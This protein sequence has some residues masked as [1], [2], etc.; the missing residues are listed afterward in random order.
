MTMNNKSLKQLVLEE[1]RYMDGKS[2]LE[3]IE[4]AIE[5]GPHSLDLEFDTSSREGV[6]AVREKGSAEDPVV[7]RLEGK[8]DISVSDPGTPLV[9]IVRTAL[10]KNRMLEEGRMSPKTAALFFAENDDVIE[11]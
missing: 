5:H 1:Y 9:S 6:L 3:Q 11:E 4:K 7:V 10:S 8:N 2:R